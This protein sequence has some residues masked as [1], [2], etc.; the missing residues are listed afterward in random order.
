MP[1]PYL[2]LASK[3]GR[4]PTVREGPNDHRVWQAL[5]DGRATAQISLARRLAR[6]ERILIAC[7]PVLH[8]LRL[9]LRQTIF[10]RAMLLTAFASFRSESNCRLHAKDLRKLGS[11]RLPRWIARAINYGSGST[12]VI[13][14][15][16]RGWRALP[17]SALTRANFSRRRAQW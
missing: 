15:T 12:V 5:P 7:L 16:W 6:S 1:C 8:Q 11:F 10:D 9:R 2:R 17:K 4:S 14:A 13:K 3:P